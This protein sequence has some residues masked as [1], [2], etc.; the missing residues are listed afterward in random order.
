MQ[1]KA[2]PSGAKVSSK[3]VARGPNYCSSRKSFP[4]PWR[5]EIKGSGKMSRMESKL[6]QTQEIGL[7]V[8]LPELCGETLYFVAF[9]QISVSWRI[10][11]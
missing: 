5:E 7:R 9:S 4:L 8:S 11:G 10:P 3:L 2:Y 1:A 6:Y